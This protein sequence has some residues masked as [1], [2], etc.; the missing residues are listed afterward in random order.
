LVVVSG[1]AVFRR[2]APAPPTPG[3]VGLAS[4]YGPGFDGK[5]TASGERFEQDDLTAAHRRLRLGTRV[6][7]TNLRNERAV[8]VRINDR[9]PYGR[10]RV[11]DLSRAAARR[12]GMEDHGLAPVRVEVLDHASESSATVE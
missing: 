5:R 11:I 2:E 1:C 7:V 3:E 9:G 12:I 8:I 10:G 4:W 6:R